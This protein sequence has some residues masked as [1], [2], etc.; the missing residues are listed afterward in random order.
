L[1]RHH[2]AIEDRPDADF[3]YESDADRAIVAEVAKIAAERGVARAQVA[4]AWLMGNPAV[5]APIVGAGKTQHLD[6]AI[7]ALDLHLT[8]EEMAALEAPYQPRLAALSLWT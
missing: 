5:T 3:L 8:D 6:D 7:A 1:E 2:R 4:L